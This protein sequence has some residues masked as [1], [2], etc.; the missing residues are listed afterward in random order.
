MTHPCDL[1]ISYSSHDRPWA[2]K[3]YEDLRRSFPAMSIFWDR[4]SILA[5]VAW[6]AFLTDAIANKT[7][8]LLILWSDAAQDSRE[9]ISEIATFEAEV[10]RTEILEGSKR[11]EFIITLQGTPGGGLETRQGFPGLAPYY[12]LNATDRGVAVL[13]SQAEAS[14]EWKRVIR[15]IGDAVTRADKARPVLAAVIAQNQAHLTLLDRIHDLPQMENGATLDD[16]L[17]R[18]ALA[19]ADVRAR[20]GTTAL[21]WHPYGEKETVVDLL[22]DLRVQANSRLIPKYWFRWEYLD[23]TTQ[24]DRIKDLH[25]QPSVVL[26]DPVSLF[27]VVCAN[28]LR[29]LEK[30]LREEQSV[31][32]SLAPLRQ[33]GMDWFALA[34]KEQAV[35]VLNDYFEPSIPPVAGFAKCAINV[36]R[37]TD[38]ERLIRSRLGSFYLAQSRAEARDTTG[39]ATK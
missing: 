31:L 35:P 9:V 38:L 10:R 17:A 1:F 37:I 2:E 3:V 22:E 32:V 30:Y 29:R 5:G 34:M 15:M 28:A 13:S 4:E 21:D 11:E 27:N 16:F 19:W 39:M 7:K 33:E 20:Y 25:E 18:Y 14:A 8:H 24:I 36:P 12:N 6:R 23:L 26:L